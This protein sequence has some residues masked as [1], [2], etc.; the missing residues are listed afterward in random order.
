VPAFGTALAGTLLVLVKA[1]LVAGLVTGVRWVLGRVDI[2][3]VRGLTLRVGLPGSALLLGLA[4][5]ARQAPF[6]RVLALGDRGL[7]WACLL[8]WLTLA[9]VVARRVA[10]RRVALEGERGPNPWL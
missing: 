7:A 3:E 10:P 1:W 8:G 4:E 5:L 9:L 6:E 2:D